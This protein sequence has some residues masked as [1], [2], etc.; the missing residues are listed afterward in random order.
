MHPYIHEQLVPLVLEERRRQAPL[1]RT[2]S[3]RPVARR[4]GRGLVAVGTALASTG[5]RLQEPAPDPACASCS[6]APGRGSIGQDFA[7]PAQNSGG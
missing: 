7:A 3:T 2:R 1:R 5:R 6:G 4:A